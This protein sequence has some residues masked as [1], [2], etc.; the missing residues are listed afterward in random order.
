ME[1]E[2]N[3]Y[4][5]T[6]RAEEIAQATKD[7]DGGPTDKASTVLGKFKDVNALTRAYE[8][9]QAEF[10]RR[11]QKWRELEKTVENFKRPNGDASGAEKLRKNAETR[12]AAAKEFDAF[13]ADMGASVVKNV[14]PNEGENDGQ[15]ETNVQ[16]W[17]TEERAAA[18]TEN[19]EGVEEAALET[20]NATEADKAFDGGQAARKF[21]EEQRTE[22]AKEGLRSEA[23]QTAVDGVGT[24][25]ERQTEQGERAFFAAKESA[26]TRLSS[27]ELFKQ[28]NGDEG[29]R[30][31]IIGEYLSS[32]GKT[33]APVTAG[34]VGTL[35][36]PPIKAKTIDD[37]G[38]MA[39]AY[40]RKNKEI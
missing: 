13:I 2:E 19:A 16:P 40:F 32:L 36:T 26:R 4:E 24:A 8:S 37:A 12:R 17:E 22:F 18:R 33:G 38:N 10:T 25:R 23:G 35:A 20:E 21:G 14:K 5:E 1:K 34:G 15:E 30:L 6:T 39:L 7:A 3:V 11:S 28:A 29:V 27:D 9:L 31:R